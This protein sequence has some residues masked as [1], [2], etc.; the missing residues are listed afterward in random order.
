M[1]V[2]QCER[3]RSGALFPEGSAGQ[4]AG[5]RVAVGEQSILQRM[6]RD[7][8]EILEIGDVVL[9]EAPRLGADHA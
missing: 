7:A 4:S 5:E 1:A 8:R 6:H 3:D 2:A 9:A